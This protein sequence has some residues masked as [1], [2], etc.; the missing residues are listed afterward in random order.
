MRSICHFPS[1][2]L[3]AVGLS[4]ALGTSVHGATFNIEDSVQ[5]MHWQSMSLVLGDERHFRA[6][7]THSYSDAS[8]SLNATAGVC[9]LPWL[10]MRVELDERQ[11]KSR[12]VNLVPA[13]LRVDEAIRHESMAEFITE[14]GDSGFYTHFYLN[15]VTSLI[16]EMREG[17]AFYLGFEQGEQAPWYMTFSLQGAEAAIER[18]QAACHANTNASIGT[19]REN[20]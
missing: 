14:R 6:V 11:G 15:D 17:D 20:R 13:R 16:E 5:H 2:F 8:L 1:R 19:G 18:M 7:E 4:L 12:A 9:D 3:L 10:E